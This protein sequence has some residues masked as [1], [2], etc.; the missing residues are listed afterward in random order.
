MSSTCSPSLGAATLFAFQR[1]VLSMMRW[2]PSPFAY[3]IHFFSYGNDSCPLRRRPSFKDPEYFASLKS[4]CKVSHTSPVV[5]TVPYVGK[6]SHYCTRSS[7]ERPSLATLCASRRRRS[8]NE[9]KI[10]RV[11]IILQFCKQ[12]RE[13]ESL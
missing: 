11:I 2:N 3:S 7:A 8:P 4:R 9:N 6:P 10:P 13:V 12:L 1:K 5:S